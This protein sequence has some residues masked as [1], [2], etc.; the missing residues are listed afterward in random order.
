MKSYM[1]CNFLK[2]SP[3]ESF[4]INNGKGADIMRIWFKRVCRDDF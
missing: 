1:D 4:N 2:K 3:R